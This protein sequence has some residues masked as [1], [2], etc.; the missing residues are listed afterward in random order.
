[1]FWFE[2]WIWLVFSDYRSNQSGLPLLDRGGLSLLIRPWAR[3]GRWST[4]LV[5]PL[6]FVACAPTAAARAERG[7]RRASRQWQTAKGHGARI[8]ARGES[9]VMFEFGALGGVASGRPADVHWPTWGM[10]R[11]RNLSWIV[12]PFSSPLMKF[13]KHKT[14]PRSL[15]DS[16]VVEPHSLPALPSRQSCGRTSLPHCVEAT[17]QHSSPRA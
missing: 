14:C 12:N 16:P 10:S 6:Q 3:R 5:E 2:I 8:R 1:V 4:L 7:A 13:P 11:T 17:H 9:L 15:A